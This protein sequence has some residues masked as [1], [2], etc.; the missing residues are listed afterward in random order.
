LEWNSKRPKSDI[1]PFI[2]QHYSKAREQ[3]LQKAENSLA[4]PWASIA[5][6]ER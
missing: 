4:A 5:Q 1:R 2:K 3:P 6:M